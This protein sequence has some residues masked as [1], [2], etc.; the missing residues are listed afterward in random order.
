MTHY[1]RMYTSLL[2]AAKRARFPRKGKPLKQGYYYARLKEGRDDV[3]EVGT[4]PI[5]TVYEKTDN[6]NY[7]RHRLPSKKCL[8]MDLHYTFA[9]DEL[10]IRLADHYAPFNFHDHYTKDEV[11][12]L[13]L[14]GQRKPRTYV[15]ITVNNFLQPLH[16]YHKGTGGPEYPGF[17]W[18]GPTNEIDCY[19]PVRYDPETGMLSVVQA[20]PVRVVDDNLRLRINAALKRVFKHT[21]LLSR[22]G[23]ELTKEQREQAVSQLRPLS[24]GNFFGVIQPHTVLELLEAFDPQDELSVATTCAALAGVNAY[25]CRLIQPGHIRLPECNSEWNQLRRNLQ[26]VCKVRSFTV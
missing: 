4:Y 15:N 8:A 25:G 5:P 26:K 10:L 14:I 13:P 6:Y 9:P 19:G 7:K 22:M 21:R 17:R 1:N 24:T 23:T 11:P 16:I 2:S 18:V 12:F 3:V 20:Q